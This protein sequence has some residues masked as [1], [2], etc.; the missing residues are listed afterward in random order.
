[1]A[2][3]ML[4]QLENLSAD[5]LAVLPAEVSAEYRRR[6]MEIW[7]VVPSE[8]TP[9]V[10]PSEPT[11]EPAPDASATEMVRRKVVRCYVYYTTDSRMWHCD[12][13]CEEIRSHSRVERRTVK[14]IMD[15][16][17]LYV[18]HWL[19]ELRIGPCD[20]CTP[21]IWEMVQR[22]HPGITVPELQ[23]PVQLSSSGSGNPSTSFGSSEIPDRTE[24]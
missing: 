3:H 17:V 21:N 8:P 14:I 10:V 24:M 16:D 15:A 9:G 22:Q 2:R 11:P 5:E 12:N 6:A 1:M 18:G 4:R 20:L 13:L 23:R 19:A 7:G